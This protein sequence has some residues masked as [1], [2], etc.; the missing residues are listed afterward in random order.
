MHISKLTVVNYRNFANTTLKF[1]KGVNTI[2]GENGSGK[3]NLFRAIRLLLDDNMFRV[4]HKLDETDFHRGL[5][6]WQGHWIIISMEFDEI[7]PDEAIQALF[8]HGTGV[9]AAGAVEKATYNLIFRPKKEIR[10]KLAALDDLDMAGLEAIRSAIT[11][12]DYE[13]WF[14]GRSEADFGDAAVYQSLVGDFDNCVFSSETRRKIHELARGCL[15]FFPL[16]KSCLS[17]SFRHC[18]MSLPSFITTV[19]IRC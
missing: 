2:I 12:A 9:V 5:A 15:R 4:A 14:T 16:P 3:T 13:T 11:I 8:L 17:L 6:R 18:A 10:L 19:L 7:G 1:G